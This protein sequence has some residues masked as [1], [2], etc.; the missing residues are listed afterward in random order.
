MT[1]QRHVGAIR[2]I[3]FLASKGLTPQEIYDTFHDSWNFLRSSTYSELDDLIY[4]T[5]EKI[6]NAATKT[7]K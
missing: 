1:E 5:L 3:E 7:E 6:E 2:R 4:H